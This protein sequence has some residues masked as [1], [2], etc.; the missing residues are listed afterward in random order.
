MNA[1]RPNKILI[2]AVIRNQNMFFSTLSHKIKPL[3]NNKLPGFFSGHLAVD[4]GTPKNCLSQSF[5]HIFIK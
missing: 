1:I 2:F 5:G 4:Q 3:N